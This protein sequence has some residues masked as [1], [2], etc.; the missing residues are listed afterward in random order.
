MNGNS[1]IIE[2]VDNGRGIDLEVVEKIYKREAINAES[3]FGVR[4]ILDRL[5]LYYGES[6]PKKVMKIETVE[7]EYTKFILMLNEEKNKKLY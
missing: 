1:I 7:N 6:D 3:G 5:L 2:I 4:S